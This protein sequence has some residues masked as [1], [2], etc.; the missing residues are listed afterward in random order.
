MVAAARKDYRSLCLQTANL[1]R[2]LGQLHFAQNL[3]LINSILK[4][5]LRLERQKQNLLRSLRARV[6]V[7]PGGC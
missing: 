5:L 3:W 6:N 2:H 7:A 4:D 1:R